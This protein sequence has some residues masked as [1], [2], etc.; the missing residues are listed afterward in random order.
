MQFTYRIASPGPASTSTTPRPSLT[1][2]SRAIYLRE[3]HCCAERSIGTIA[4]RDPAYC[5][6]THR[7]TNTT[8]TQRA[9]VSSPYLPSERSTNPAIA[10]Q[11]STTIPRLLLRQ[12]SRT[13]SNTH[14]LIDSPC[15]TP[16]TYPIVYIAQHSLP[17]HIL[18]HL[19]SASAT[20]MND[21]LLFSPL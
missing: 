19:F 8:L 3:R 5:L 11:H 12:R 7:R 16:L 18:A 10:T 13:H 1:P 4:W 20:C 21:E 9:F 6:Y 17:P 14:A 2:H 15:C